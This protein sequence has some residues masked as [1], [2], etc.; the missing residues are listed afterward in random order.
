MFSARNISIKPHFGQMG[1]SYPQFCIFR[2][3]QGIFKKAIIR[4]L[5]WEL[6]YERG[7][8]FLRKNM[9]KANQTISDL[10][11]Y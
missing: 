7:H 2:C 4:A 11:F 3:C 10:I 5:Q 9:L 1:N 6:E 8:K